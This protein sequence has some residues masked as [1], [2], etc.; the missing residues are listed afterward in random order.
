MKIGI[1]IDDVLVDT[2]KLIRDHITK[3]DNNGDIINHMEEIMRGDIPNEIISKF[4]DNNILQIMNSVKIKDNAKEVLERLKK[5][6]QIVF[7][8]SRGEKKFKGTENL[9]LEYLKK[10]KINYDKI[11][12]NAFDKAKI[13]KENNIDILIDDSIKLC[14]ETFENGIRAIVFDSVV[15]RKRKTKLERVDNW[16]ELEKII[17]NNKK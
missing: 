2:S 8:T 10:Q 13:C 17:I 4:I 16:L 12:F 7:I 9:T 11:I 14:E 15:N 1:D 3:L 6:N 5:D